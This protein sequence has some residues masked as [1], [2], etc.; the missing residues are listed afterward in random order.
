MCEQSVLEFILIF[1]LKYSITL[2]N[3]M[4]KHQYSIEYIITC[5]I[6]IFMFVERQHN[7]SQK[8]KKA[9][10]SNY[11]VIPLLQHRSL[12]LNIVSCIFYQFSFT[13]YSIRL[14]LAGGNL[15]ISRLL[16]ANIIIYLRILSSSLQLI[17]TENIQ[18]IKIS[19]RK[20]N[21]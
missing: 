1:W 4:F 3:S 5:F 7:L 16:L 11:F 20:L 13:P 14:L 17:I 9:G 12:S 18:T 21:S 2:T 15:H 8:H 19:I 6:I 10:Y